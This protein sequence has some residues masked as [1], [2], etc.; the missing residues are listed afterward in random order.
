MLSFIRSLFGT[1]TQNGCGK[2]LEMQR[3][4][5]E[6]ADTLR[7]VARRYVDHLQGLSVSDLGHG[8]VDSRCALVYR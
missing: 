8:D 2:G 7:L 6:S 3:G 4:S 1:N 5:S